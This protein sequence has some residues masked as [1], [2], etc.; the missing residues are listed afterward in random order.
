[1]GRKGIRPQVL[2]D[3]FDLFDRFDHS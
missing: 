2:F 1:M 3:P